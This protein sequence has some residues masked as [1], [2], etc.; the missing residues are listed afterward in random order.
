MI[1]APLLPDGAAKSF[2]GAERFIAGIN[3]GAILPPRA[4]V[5]TNRYDG[6]SAAR[7]NR[8]MAFLGIVRAVPTNAEYLLIFRDLRQQI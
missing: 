5:A 4:S 6:I 1:T 2:D 3:T 7:G 8:G